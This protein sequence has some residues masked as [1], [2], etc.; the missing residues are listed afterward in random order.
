M[1][2]IAGDITIESFVVFDKQLRKL[3]KAQGIFKPVHITLISPGGDAQ[4]AL[5]YF[6]RI[7]R[8]TRVVHICAS[9]I[10]ASAAVLILAAGDKRFM[11]KSSWAMVHEES[12]EGLDG[13]S[14]TSMEKETAHLRRLEI[15]WATL[16]AKVTSTTAEDWA[17]L[18]KD[19]TYLSAKQCKE[20]GLIEEII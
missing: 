18:H 8:S 15:Q 13:T 4:V 1:I 2:Y 12:V 10:V 17:I 3:E 6:D 20:L 19:E 11:T 9:G 5:A 7:V 16:L 14:V